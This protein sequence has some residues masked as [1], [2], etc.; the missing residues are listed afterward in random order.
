M[1]E[2]NLYLC[3]HLKILGRVLRSSEQMNTEVWQV[4][5]VEFSDFD[6]Y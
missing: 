2:C 1:R 5:F 4:A 6:F 3:L